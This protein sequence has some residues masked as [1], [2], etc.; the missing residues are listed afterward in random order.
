MAFVS[1]TSWRSKLEKQ[2]ERRLVP[3]PPRMQK[4][5]GTGTMLIPRPL[6]VDAALRKTRAGQLITTAELRA[7]LARQFGANT[8]CPLCTGIFVRIA[9]EA[10]EEDARAGRKQL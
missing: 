8:T 2:Q 3:V 4:R 1:R 9:A 5:C 10:A 7:R 6:D